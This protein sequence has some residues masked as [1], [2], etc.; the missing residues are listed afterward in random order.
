MF[1]SR[2]KAP[3]AEKVLA[4]QAQISKWWVSLSESKKCQTCCLE[5]QFAGENSFRT[6]GTSGGWKFLFGEW[7]ELDENVMPL[8]IY[9]CPKC[10]KVEFYANEKI[11]QRLIN[12]TQ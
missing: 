2:K 1:S 8:L 10:G 7:A 4:E 3:A 6:G 12:Q 11:R 9:V 5:M